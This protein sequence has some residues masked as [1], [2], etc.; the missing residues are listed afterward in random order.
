MEEIPS[1]LPIQ[2]T[3]PQPRDGEDEQA[4]E[5]IPLTIVTGYLG[6]GKTTLLNHVLSENHGKRIAV[7]LNEFGASESPPS[8][9][10]VDVCTS[11]GKDLD[12]I[13]SSFP[14][15]QVVILKRE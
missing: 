14:S 15:L 1:L 5:K 4:I 13:F 11:C 6:S 2:D 10:S 7:I 8:P 9:S 12:S 3:L